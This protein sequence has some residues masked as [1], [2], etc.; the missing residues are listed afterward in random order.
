MN[1]ISDIRTA[2]SLHRNRLFQEYPLKSMAIFG[3]YSRGENTDESDL[4]V[5]VEF[6]GKIGIRFIDLADEIESIVGL[7]VD[8]VS[9]NGIKQGY[10]SA[11]DPDLI[12]V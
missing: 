10:L 4:D 11:I 5:L 2:L 1:S 3:S 9:R 6:H 8:L 7:K 12:Y